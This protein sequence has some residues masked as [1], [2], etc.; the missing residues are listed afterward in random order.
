MPTSTQNILAITLLGSI[1]FI[2]YIGYT[3]EASI[4]GG[5]GSPAPTPMNILWWQTS[6]CPQYFGQKLEKNN[7][8]TIASQT[9]TTLLNLTPKNATK[10]FF[11]QFC[12]RSPQ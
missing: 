1:I 3:A 4:Q 9:T 11:L 5:G 7:N 8:G 6:F 12:A 10:F 2:N